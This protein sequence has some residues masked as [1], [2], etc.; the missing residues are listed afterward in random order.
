MNH[1]LCILVGTVTVL[2]FFTTGIF[3][4]V[5]FPA[6]Y[7]HDEIIRYQYRASHIYILMSGLTNLALGL[8]P[9]AAAPVGGGRWL[10]RSG[11]AMVL[12]SPVP[13]IVAFFV[14][15]PMASPTRR[16]TLFAV[17]ML[18]AGIALL[19]AGTLRPRTRA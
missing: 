7:A 19:Y 1:K 18:A 14:E 10:A 6:A 13:F 12:L 2:V 8:K 15:P 9:A 11:L 4:S 17:V 16:W 5:I 3:M